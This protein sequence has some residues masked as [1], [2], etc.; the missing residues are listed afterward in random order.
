MEALRCS[1]CLEATS[2]I[3]REF[4]LHDAASFVGP[5]AVY[6]LDQRKWFADG[7]RFQLY[8][9]SRARYMAK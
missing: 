3:H 8:A 2:L 1:H 5:F 4:K 6:P 7:P 9:Q